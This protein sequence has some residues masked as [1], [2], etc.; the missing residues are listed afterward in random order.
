MEYL[1]QQD[2]DL[3]ITEWRLFLKR[4]ALEQDSNYKQQQAEVVSGQRALVQKNI[5]RAQDIYA[6]RVVELNREHKTRLENM[7]LSSDAQQGQQFRHTN[8]RPLP[9]SKHALDEH[10]SGKRTIEGEACATTPKRTKLYSEKPQMPGHLRP[11]EVYSIVWEDGEIYPGVLLPL[12]G[13]E[14]IGMSGDVSALLN[15]FAGPPCYRYKENETAGWAD[16]Y[17]NGGQLVHKRQY[18]ILFLDEN[19]FS[20]PPPEVRFEPPQLAMYEWVAV[21]DIKGLFQE[22]DVSFQFKEPTVRFR[23]RLLAIRERLSN[24]IP[25]T[26]SC[27]SSPHR[28]PSQLASSDGNTC[29]QAID[30][31]EADRLQLT[32]RHAI[33]QLTQAPNRPG[34][35][36]SS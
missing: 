20:V 22:A 4:K 36:F 6:V 8:Q 5:Q 2:R 3:Y 23:E 33:L 1:A 11:G 29:D 12:G 32:A 27:T 10:Q 7:R 34:T 21:H 28:S 9:T 18:P 31:V 25:N 24:E 14:G 16:G 26:I 19:K 15:G 17:I 30:S 13:F 35:A